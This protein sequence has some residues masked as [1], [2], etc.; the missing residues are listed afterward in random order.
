M[1]DKGYFRKDGEKILNAYNDFELRK[2]RNYV[3]PYFVKFGIRSV[4]DYGGGGSDWER[5]GFDPTS[6]KSAKNFFNIDTVSTFEPARYI[7]QKNKSDCVVC[8]DVLEHIYIADVANVL[9]DIF[10][11]AEKLVVL[12]VACYEAAALLPNGENAHITVRDPLWWKGVVDMVSIEFPNVYVLLICSATYTRVQIFDLWQGREWDDKDEF[13]I[14]ASKYQTFGEQKSTTN[15]KLTQDHL[16][17]LMQA[18][19]KKEPAAKKKFKDLLFRD[20][21]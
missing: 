6:N 5:E 10:G 19:I 21:D 3:K 9:R 7:L 12:N 4:L 14:D 20:G 15:V 13:K 1:A 8:M 11:H 16:I 18:L 17:V 2:F